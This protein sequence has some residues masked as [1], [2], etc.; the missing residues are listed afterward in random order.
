H[1]VQLIPQPAT[2][3]REVEVVA[4][5]RETVRERDASSRRVAGFAP[6]TRLE[7]HR[8]EQSELDD[9]AGHAVDLDEIA[10]ANAVLAHQD[11]PAEEADDEVSEGDREAG[12]GEPEERA[13]VVGRSE[14]DEQDEQHAD[15][16]QGDA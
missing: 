7:K 11:E 8:I 13:Q 4:L 1:D 14:D 5:D 15:D 16:L 2:R 6:G 9:L 12:A 3:R 10:D